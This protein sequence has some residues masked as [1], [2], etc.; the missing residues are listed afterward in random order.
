MRKLILFSLMAL[1][2]RLVAA[3]G[4]ITV[5]INPDGYSANLT[6]AGFTSGATYAFGLTAADLPGA[7]T[8]YLTVVSLGYDNTGASTT[9]TRTVYM[10]SVMRFP[11]GTASI[12]GT[13]TSGTFVDGETITEAVTGATAIIV[14]PSGQTSGTKLIARAVTGSPSTAHSWTG[15]TSGAIF[16]Q[17][18][19]VSSAFTVPTNNEEVSSTGMTV[20]VAL[21]QNVYQKDNTGG[22]N[23][24][25]APTVTIPSVFIT[26]AGG[27]SQ[28]SNAL[29]GAAVTQ[30]STRAYPVAFG[31]WAQRPYERWQANPTLAVTARA[32][33][34]INAVTIILTDTH[35]HTVTTATTKQTRQRSASGLYAEEWAA[36]CDL[37]IMTQGD[38]ITARYQLWPIVGDSTAAFDSNGQTANDNNRILGR[39][40]YPYWNDKGAIASVYAVVNFSTGN[41]STGVSSS[42][43]ATANASPYL[44]IG[45][46]ITVGTANIIYVRAGTGNVLGSTVTGPSSLGYWRQIQV[47]PSDGTVTLQLTGTAAYGAPHLSYE[48]VKIQLATGANW[49]DGSNGT[50][51]LSFMNCT[52]D[53]AAIGDNGT[54]SAFGYRSAACFLVNN[55][56]VDASK[57]GFQDDFAA[58]VCL[59]LDGNSMPCAASAGAATIYRFVANSSTSFGIGSTDNS[60]TTGPLSDPYI[61]EFNKMM[62]LKAAVTIK[63]FTGSVACANGIS[64]VGNILETATGTQQTIYIS[65]DNEA[66]TVNQAL[67]WHNTV[68]GERFNGFYNDSGTVGSLKQ[69]CSV[70]FNAFGSTS[71]SGGSSNIKADNFGTQNGNRTGNWACLYGADFVG[72]AEAKSNGFNN[73][74]VGLGSGQTMDTGGENH[75][76]GT[77][78]SMNFKTDNSVSGTGT[79][80]GDYTPTTGSALLKLVP[81]GYAVVGWDLNGVPINN[82]GTGT[83]GA[84]QVVSATTGPAGALMWFP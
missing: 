2:V 54:V 1:A 59:W 66:A 7:N 81:S 65:A 16:A 27:A 52:M 62:N 23:S 28:T 75:T 6:I 79:G 18:G 17:V 46:A 20:R 84:I 68:A 76:N 22:G 26:N 73:A 45:K 31:Q 83:A 67:I 19:S 80:N 71:T 48:G 82:T 78:C 41:D 69:N 60:A 64:V 39:C 30:S 77:V 40:N 44:T 70:K 9:T 35:S 55:T 58:R 29:S 72:S 3:T 34:G 51:Y 38:V 47:Y 53:P 14:G 43:L 33:Y 21:S 25:T 32:L 37:S 63:A 11:F 10:T 57:W 13:F 50:N 36:T 15:G 61:V 56:F 8:P 4:D 24:G 74:F 49:F 5:T 42:T 12:P